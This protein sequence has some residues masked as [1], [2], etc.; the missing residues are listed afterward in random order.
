MKTVNIFQLKHKETKNKES[1]SNKCKFLEIV[2]S[3][4]I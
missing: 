4:T 1:P 2:Q 3:Q